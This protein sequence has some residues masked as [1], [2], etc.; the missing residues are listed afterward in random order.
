MSRKA[1]LTPSQNAMLLTVMS[2]TSD[3]LQWFRAPS[4]GDRV[5]L[6]SLYKHGLLQR[7]A[8]RGVEGSADAA[9]EYRLSSLVMEILKG[10]G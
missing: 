6:A 1:K 9:H 8:W 5:T 2:E 3:P 10:K 4:H 7:R